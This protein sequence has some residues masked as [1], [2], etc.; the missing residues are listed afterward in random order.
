MTRVKFCGMTRPEDVRQA[1]RLGA[2]YVGVVL[3]TSPR[4]VAAEEAAR[5]LAPLEGSGVRSVGVFG[6]EP[7]ADVIRMADAAGVDVIQ[8]H[9][10][11]RRS[12]FDAV[13]EALGAE[14]WRVIRVGPAGLAAE[15]RAGFRDGDGTLLD[16]MAAG[17]LGG[18]GQPFDWDRAARDVATLRAGRVIILAGG[19]RP[20]NVGEAIDRLAPDVVDV[21]SGVESAPGIKEHGLM[22]DFMAAA[23]AARAGR[24]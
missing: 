5:L 12:D 21:S 2:A 14:A 15:D 3:T 10:A 7:V 4:R 1:V 20:G 18:T 24:R 19:L 23:G 13:R 8:L 6:S 11:R 9:G 17:S 22:A 16:T